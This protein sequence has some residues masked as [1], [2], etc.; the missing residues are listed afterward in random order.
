MPSV[1][2]GRAFAVGADGELAR[3][4]AIGI[5]RAADECAELADLERKPAIGAGGAFARVG[6]VA[7]VGEDVRAQHFV[8]AV[9]IT[10]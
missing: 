4:A 5:V 1:R 2:R 8:Q 7:L 3:E 9:E 10:I 6:A